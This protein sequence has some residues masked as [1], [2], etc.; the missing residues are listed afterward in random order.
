MKIQ[1]RG[2]VVAEL[3]LSGRFLPN[4]RVYEYIALHGKGA[5]QM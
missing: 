1:W 3:W 4:S 5:L 2:V